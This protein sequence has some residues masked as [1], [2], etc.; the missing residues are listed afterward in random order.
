M[1]LSHLQYC[2]LPLLYLNQTDVRARC[3]HAGMVAEKTIA[4][5][6]M[7]CVLDVKSE[8]EDKHRPS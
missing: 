6:L 4:D 3:L 1:C 2:F 7:V 5:E 8:D